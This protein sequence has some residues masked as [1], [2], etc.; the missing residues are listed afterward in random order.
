MAD[1]PF[2]LDDPCTHAGGHED[3]DHSGLCIYCS[4]LLDPTAKEIQQ[5]IEGGR[6]PATLKESI[7][8]REARDWLMAR[9]ERTTG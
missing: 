4:G 6:D 9:A 3:P 2:A 8:W 1:R 5:A 7:E